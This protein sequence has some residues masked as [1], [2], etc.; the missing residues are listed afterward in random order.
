MRYWVVL[1]QHNVHLIHSLQF[2]SFSSSS[3][4]TFERTN[5]F[6]RFV[7]Q[8]TV[9]FVKTIIKARQKL[10][11]GRDWRST[12][13]RFYYVFISNGFAWGCWRRQSGTSANPRDQQIGSINLQILELMKKQ[14]KVTALPFFL[15]FRQLIYPPSLLTFFLVSMISQIG[16]GS[17]APRM[18]VAKKMVKAGE[19]T[20]FAK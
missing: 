11:N 5:S 4:V 16:F 19:N 20:D 15:I 2:E 8:T 7:D 12:R 13:R 1:W 3:S 14:G 18:S 9:P 6:R 10:N 17:L